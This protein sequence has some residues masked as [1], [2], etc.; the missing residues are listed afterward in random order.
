MGR[1]G[2]IVLFSTLLLIAGCSHG[3]ASVD[4]AA[5][6]THVIIRDT[7][8]YAVNPLQLSPSDGTFKRGTHVAILHDSGGYVKVR[9]DKNIVG[10]IQ[11]GAVR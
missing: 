8:Y 7:P 9:T 6:A 2:S 4:A 5:T 10:Y 3:H 1:L 11:R